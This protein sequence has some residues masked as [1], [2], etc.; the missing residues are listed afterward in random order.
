MIALYEMS[1]NVNVVSRSVYTF[2]NVIGDVGGFNGVLVSV[3]ATLVSIFSYQKSANFLVYQLYYASGPE[4]PE[5]LAS[6]KKNCFSS[7]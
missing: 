1:L 7:D 2:W 5:F 4:A 6:D 3:C